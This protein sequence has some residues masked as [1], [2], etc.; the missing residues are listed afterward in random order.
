MKGD[1]NTNKD[2]LQGIIS[3]IGKG[4]F[5]IPNF[6]R[7]F[8]WEPSHVREL[9]R[10]IF[11]DY[12]IGNLLLW[13]GKDEIFDVLACK[14]IDGVKGKDNRSKIVLDG[15]QRL[16]AM[17][18][19]FMGPT[20]SYPNRASRF[21][22]FVYVDQFMGQ[23]YDDAFFYEYGQKGE[24]L[25]ED[26]TNQFAKNIFPLSVIGDTIGMHDWL[27]GYEDY[28]KGQVDIANREKT[29]EKVSVA[30]KHAKN[31]RLFYEYLVELINSY[32]VSFIELDKDIEIDKVCD[33][34]TQINSR[35]M[36]LDIFDLIN[37]ML[38][39]QG[40]QLKQMYQDAELELSFVDSD[41][42]NVYLLQVMSILKQ[43]YCSPKYLYYLIPGRE[44][45]IRDYNGH[46]SI[47]ILF[48]NGSKFK[49]Y[50]TAAVNSM[51]SVIELLKSSQEYGAISSK[52]IPYA[53]IL[54]PFAALNEWTK[55]ISFDKQLDANHKIRSWYW[56]SVFLRR[57]SGS[58]QVTTAKDFIDVKKWVE[59]DIKPS[60]FA[61]AQEQV[62]RI[63]LYTE[64]RGGTSIYNGVFN[65]LVL[66]KA[67]DWY[68][69]EAPQ[70]DNIDDHHIVPKS[71][72]A[73]Q[74]F[75]EGIS[76]DTILNR[77]LLT[78]TTNREV[79]GDKLPNEYLPELVEKY[80][81]DVRDILMS[82]FISEEAFNVLMRNPFEMGDYEEFIKV[83]QKTIRDAI[84]DATG[85]SGAA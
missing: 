55:H 12:Y 74:K 57:Y 59:H 63:N 78:S 76:I 62:P 38:T 39:P 23:N 56:I 20:T 13:K 68:T 64:T 35:G 6:Q 11:L 80:G 54:P 8:E 67:T 36:K 10:S 70:Y 49:E 14:P 46:L 22:F 1:L 82:H 18:Y 52:F 71:W 60:F 69:G 21:L 72:G 42:M 81:E 45:K 29:D 43:D 27:R 66:E 77:T 79:I 47:D 50:W 33:I 58:V 32:H 28:W 83:R 61:E 85:I 34:F 44:R 31:A 24:K 19:A 73:K 40:I 7:D 2:S 37:A 5:V 41:R 15:Q 51:K 9:I 26:R 16:T 25:L 53:S 84:R 17:Y 30:S 3:D 48:S 75:N 65:L 4:V